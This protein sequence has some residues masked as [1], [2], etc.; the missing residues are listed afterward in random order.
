MQSTLDG[1]DA[2]ANRG[3]A[4]EDAIQIMTPKKLHHS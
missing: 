3:S 4:P 2:A 1:M